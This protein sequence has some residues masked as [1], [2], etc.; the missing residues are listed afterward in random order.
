VRI[1]IFGLGYVG[2]VTAA[3]LAAQGH[4]VVGVDVNNDKVQ[5]IASGETPIIEPGLAELIRTGVAGG[6]IFATTDHS[7]ALQG[8]DMALVTVGTPTSLTGEADLSF[9][10]RVV[11]Q[12]GACCASALQPPVVVLRSTVPPGTLDG[13]AAL[14]KE[15][16]PSTGFHLAFNPEFLR[17]G[18]AVK[19]FLKPPYTVVGTEDPVAERAVR[20]LYRGLDAPLFV[21]APRTAEML[22]YVANAWHATKIV[23]ANEV[24]RIA[25]GFG[26]DG[27][28]IMN[29]IV[30][31]RKLNVSAAYMRP[32]FAFGGSCLPKD[33]ASMLY[34]ARAM[35]APAPLLSGVQESNRLH[36]EL[37]AEEMLRFGR[38]RIGVLGLA[39][40]P[41]TDDLRESPGVVLCK[42]LIGEGCKVRIFDRAVSAARLTG[43]NLAYIREKLPH[44]ES[45]LEA[46]PQDAIRDAELVAVTYASPEFADALTT[47]PTDAVVFDL[48]RMLPAVSSGLRFDDIAR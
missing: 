40:K 39:F 35:N 1:C 37:V 28:E 9:V 14:L 26:V 16:A 29:L 44:L 2:A 34:H 7:D 32:G 36:I 4:R 30:E 21:V 27:R 23:F 41:G 10:R 6:L 43:T 33:L 25:R 46:S 48:A 20:E 38:R 12:I 8:A 19:D 22:K 5:R 11:V 15:T 17:E 24:E 3:C 18:S 42:R 31:D 47:A 45:L 13:C